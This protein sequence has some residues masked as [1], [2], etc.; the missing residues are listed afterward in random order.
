MS[1]APAFQFYSNDFLV[2]TAMLSVEEVGAYIRLLCFQ[3]DCGGLPNDKEK[4]ARLAGCGVATIEAIWGKFALSDDGMVRNAR[5]EE[6]RAGLER[7]K[8]LQREKAQKRWGGDPK[9]CHGN[10]TAMPRDMPEACHGIATASIRH[11]PEACS[12]SS[13]SSSIEDIDSAEPTEP[14][15]PSAPPEPALLTFSTVGPVQSWNLTQ[16]FVDKL[17]EC[18]PHHDILAVCRKAKLWIETNPAKRK[19]AKGMPA[20]LSKWLDREANRP[21]PTLFQPQQRSPQAKLQAF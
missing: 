21:Q 9:T 18:Y 12:S 1:K 17:K 15:E 13:S 8:Q 11:M 10:A 7:F 5:L 16:S 4:L 19:T 3:W 20:F 2:G 6:S 14:V